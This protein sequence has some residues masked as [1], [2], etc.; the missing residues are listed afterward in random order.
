MIAC[1]MDEL[2]GCWWGE[3]FHTTH[4]IEYFI[5]VVYYQYTDVKKCFSVVNSLLFNE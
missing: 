2:I 1:R 5:N 4:I 3:M